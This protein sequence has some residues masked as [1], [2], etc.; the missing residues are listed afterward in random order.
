MAMPLRNIYIYTIP[1][2]D[3]LNRSQLYWSPSK[4]RQGHA[5]ACSFKF[6]IASSVTNFIDVTNKDKVALSGA[7]AIAVQGGYA[8]VAG[9]QFVWQSELEGLAQGTARLFLAVAQLAC[10]NACAVSQPGCWLP[11]QWKELL[12]LLLRTL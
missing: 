8:F 10:E 2:C 3:K 5:L 4:C 9:L 11:A 12:F 7:R 6:R 1:Y